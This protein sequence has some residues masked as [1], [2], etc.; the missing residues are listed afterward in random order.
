MGAI[1]RIL[2]LRSFSSSY[3]NYISM[4]TIASLPRMSREELSALLLSNEASKVGV[5]DVRDGDHVGGHIRA[6]THVPSSTLDHRIPE[7]IRTMVEKEIVVFHCALSQQR[8]PGAALRYMRERNN[9]LSKEEV[10]TKA[11]IEL[12]NGSIQKVPSKKSQEQRV[13]VLD[14]GFV[15]WQER[16]DSTLPPLGLGFESIAC[17][18]VGLTCYCRYGKDHRLTDAYAPDIWTDYY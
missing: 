8:G 16:Y 15:G 9:K 14:K 2:N 6:S 4:E 18:T 13:Y 17:N 11:G 12:I 1:D 10:G 3:S 7:I 5:I